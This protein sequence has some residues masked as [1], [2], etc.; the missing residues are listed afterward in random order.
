VSGTVDPGVTSLLFGLGAHIESDAMIFDTVFTVRP[1]HLARLGPDEAV[2]FT[3]KIIWA[4]AARLR[5]PPT[6]LS[7]SFRIDV[8]DGGVDASVDVDAVPE[9]S[10]LGKGRNV[11]QVKSGNFKPWQP[12]QISE[13][14]FGDK[15]P[16]RCS[17]GQPVRACMDVGGRY[18]LLC[19]GVDPTLQQRDDA[20]EELRRAFVDC[21]YS[22]PS[23][24]VIGQAQLIAMLEAFPSL[25]LEL[26]GNGVGYFDTLA[27]WSAQAQMRYTFKEGE[28]QREFVAALASRIRSSEAAVHVHLCG[29]AGI[30]KTRLAL[31]ALRADDLAPLLV[32]CDGPSRIVDSQLLAGLL[33]ED[34]RLSLILVV[35]ECDADAR[36]Y[37]W[38][39]FKHLGPR[40]RFISIYGESGD[41]GGETVCMNAPGLEDEQICEILS[42]YLP[43]GE[44]AR[45]WS[46]LCDGSP[47]VAHVVGL[48]LRS[49]PEDLLKAPDTVDVW[50][51]YIVGDDRADS[52]AVEQ[53][54]VVLRRVALFKRFGFGHAVRGE[55]EAIAGLVEG[56][57][58]SI[59]RA[60]FE[61]IVAELRGRRIL[62]GEN[63]LYITP[64]LLHIKLWVEWWEIHGNSFVLDDLAKSVP[65]S[66]LDWFFEMAKYAKQSL[67]AEKVFSSLLSEDGPFEQSGLLKDARGA[68]FFLSIAE[69]CPRE[70]LRCLKRTVGAWSREELWDFRTGR[71]EVVWALERIAV[72]GPLFEDA[73]RLL[74]RLAEAENEEYFGNNA[75]GVFTGLFSPGRGPVAPTEA[76][77]EE[78]FP[79]L[80]DA[81]E[82]GSKERRRIGL[83][84]AEQALQTHHFSRIVGPEHQGLRLQPKLWVPKTWGELF[85]AYR[86][87]WRL[88]EERLGELPPSERTATLDVMLKGARGL[89]G[90]ANL[91]S[92]VC[93]FF[94]ELADK[95]DVDGTKIIRVV[96]HVLR[97]D[98]KDFDADRREAWEELRQVLVTDD[99]PSRMRRWVEM[100]FIGDEVDESGKGIGRATQ[101]IER[102]ASEAFQDPALLAS[103]LPWLVTAAAQN[104]FGF[105]YALGG[106]DIGFTLL[107]DLLAA[108]RNAGPNGSAFFLSGYFR[109]L[110]EADERAWEEQ[111]DL[112]SAD[113]ALR[114]YVPE[115]TQRSGLNDRAAERLL[116]LGRHGHIP[117]HAF[118][119]F[120]YGGAVRR[121]RPERLRDWLAFL[122][123]VG[124]REGAVCALELCYFYYVFPEPQQPLPRDMTYRVVT[125]EP[126]FTTDAERGN[127]TTEEHEWTELAKAFIEQHPDSSIALARLML[128]HF[129]RRG[130]IVGVAASRTGSVLESVLQDSPEEM[131]DSMVSYLGPPVDSRAFE[132]SHWLREGAFRFVPPALVWQWVEED[133]E[134]RAVYL[135]SFVP[136]E[137]P[138]TPETVSIR[139][140]LI[141]YGS[142]AEVRSSLVGNH[143]SESWMGSES[144]HAR[145]R[146]EQLES[147]R[148]EETNGNVMAWLEDYIEW[149]T[150]RVAHAKVREERED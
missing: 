33:R 45:R 18:I 144:S 35:D 40:L 8:P 106:R 136:R 57:D 25:C 65:P 16:L 66:L 140:V 4:E 67:A 59:T 131:W 9:G 110:R 147:W 96:E 1:E 141:R 126:L 115:L 139:E 49:N 39:K 150:A 132:I 44:D 145:S 103:Q 101:E 122:L 52:Q 87:V 95:P 118:R 138:G 74:L 37:L 100:T 92:M 21:G 19:T 7:I 108:Q 15:P 28:P 93:E 127:F 89:A 77:P 29:E 13:E 146:L 51:R 130:T 3:A 133:V 75:T 149:T 81:L 125:A 6:A 76:S 94:R 113:R 111:L 124:S 143:L 85:D 70:A 58:P 105:G 30:G 73:A 42:E 64:R 99:F 23:V 61:V 32:Y 121:L 98:A 116:N 20:V 47:R 41:S 79:V 53:R 63:T 50:D 82:H 5:L 148:K 135:S 78:R 12:N 27:T 112:A 2:R 88:L 97:Y 69:A 119:M 24:D 38:N 48:N 17:L 104:G 56:D 84:A 129:G 120:A 83:L 36:Y 109:A 128:E 137:F 114:G 14:L 107:S 123:G 86:R 54:R 102:L 62:Q 31:E 142:R 46:E 34:S 90:M 55:A 22:G 68:R 26:N 117:V 43:S 60:R 10:V 72:W 91:S 134:E 71:Q 80:R 11:I